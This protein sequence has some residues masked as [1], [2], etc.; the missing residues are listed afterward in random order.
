MLRI[1]DN[2]LLFESTT[3]SAEV[4]IFY[5]SSSQ[6]VCEVRD[7]GQGGITARALSIS[8]SSVDSNNDLTFRIRNKGKIRSIGFSTDL[9]IVSVQRED[10]AMDFI[11]L[12][13][14]AIGNGEISSTDNDSPSN[15]LQTLRLEIRQPCQHLDGIILGVRWVSCTQVLLVTDQG[16]ELYLINSRRRSSKLVKAFNLPVSWSQVHVGFLPNY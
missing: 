15:F 9:K 12:D 1:G 10:S 7:N 13:A 3:T 4:D 14:V 16:P 2:F 6:R 5:D 11:I 8:P